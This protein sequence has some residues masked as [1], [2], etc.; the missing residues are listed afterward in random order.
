[1]SK[2]V[3]HIEDNKESAP[4]PHERRAA[5]ILA[6][7]FQSDIVFLRRLRSK[8]PDLYVLKTNVRWELKSPTGSG[9]HTI[10]NNLREAVKQSNNIILDLHRT[11][12]T[13]AQAIARIRE[14][15]RKE[16]H[17]IKRLKV[18]AKD[19]RVIDLIGK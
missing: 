3:I 16:R 1:M 7:Y 10:Q 2:F 4:R 13:D 14:Y 8:N 11:G 5:E 19:Q 17:S 15:I 12:L 6:E 18:L 9:K